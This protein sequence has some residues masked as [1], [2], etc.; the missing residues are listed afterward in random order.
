MGWRPSGTSPG[1]ISEEAHNAGMIEIAV[2]YINRLR[3]LGA[4]M[5]G[6][7]KEK[8][9]GDEAWQSLTNLAALLKKAPSM[10]VLLSVEDIIDA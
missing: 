8:D 3:T 6:K 1:D 9:R 4:R 10:R 7:G 5:T 2:G